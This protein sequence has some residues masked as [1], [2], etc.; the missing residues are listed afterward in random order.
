MPTSISPMSCLIT[1]ALGGTGLSAH[2]DVLTVSPQPGVADFQS[3]QAAIDAAFDGDEIRL[4]DGVYTSNHPVY[5]AKLRGKGITLSAVDPGG[6]GVIIDGEGERYGIGCVEGEGANTLISDL[7]FRNCRYPY[8]SGLDVDE[9]GTTNWAHFHHGGA[10]IINWHTQ[11]NIRNCAFESN[12]MG[13]LSWG[14]QPVIDQ[15][16]FE[17]NVEGIRA[18]NDVYDSELETATYS[19][20][21]FVGNGNGI[22][23][24]YAGEI[25]DCS[26]HEN[27]N[28]VSQGLMDLHIRGSYFSQ[29]GGE[30]MDGGAVYASSNTTIEDCSFT[31]NFGRNGGAV[32]NRADNTVFNQLV[33]IRNCDFVGNRAE[34]GGAIST[35]FRGLTTKGQCFFAGNQASESGGA[36]HLTLTGIVRGLECHFTGNSAPDGAGLFLTGESVAELDLCM[37][38]KQDADNRGG[39]IGLEGESTLKM[40]HCDFDDLGAVH[41]GGAISALD[42]TIELVGGMFNGC[43]AGAGGAINLENSTLDATTVWFYFNGSN[44]GGGAIMAADSS[45]IVIAG[46]NFTN[47]RTDGSGG[48]IMLDQSS[49]VMNYGYF[50][51]NA[52]GN[53]GGAVESMNESVMEIADCAFY[54]S[55]I[56]DARYGGAIDIDPTAGPAFLQNLMVSGCDSTVMGGGIYSDGPDTVIDR[57]SVR[58]NHS[59]LGGGVGSFEG[60]VKIRSS[61][62]CGNT[63]DQVSNA[64]VDLGNNHISEVCCIADLNGDGLVDGAD[65]TTLL[66]E[67]GGCGEEGCRADLDQDGLV[68]GADMTILLGSWGNCG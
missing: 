1:L 40:I 63:L 39:A 6:R 11:P 62:I 22:N 42:S 48:G 52:A 18:V 59:P 23:S 45:S 13:V 21:T 10:G 7:V 64:F 56:D 36:H 43:S 34:R 53:Y 5:V 46:P 55:D 19:N 2:A 38:Q 44:I 51:G 16:Y 37:F 9:D 24:S 3:L 20:S 27:E 65:L 30:N 57:C 12:N 35:G 26:F 47:N 68:D 32:A 58:G 41:E 54:G 31:G 50:S 33:T 25:I 49:L 17:D 67:W 4:H 66:G 60:N 61:F 14:A 15:C 28:A 29:N 8:H